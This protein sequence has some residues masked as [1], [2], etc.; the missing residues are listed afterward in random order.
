MA[1]AFLSYS[2]ADE[3]IV[4]RIRE[5]LKDAG[6]STFLDRARLAAGQ[7]WQPWLEREIADS[8]A[9]LVFRR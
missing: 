3:A 2:R 9:C 5:R 1:D 8:E 6:L 4:R 7:P